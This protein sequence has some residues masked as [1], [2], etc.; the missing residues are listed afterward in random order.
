MEASRMTKEEFEAAALRRLQHLYPRA[1][2]L[3][4]GQLE[5]AILRTPS[6]RPTAHRLRLARAWAA[7]CQNGE[8]FDLDNYLT[9]VVGTV[10]HRLPPDWD[11]ARNL[12]YPKLLNGKQAITPGPAT[13]LFYS[14]TPELGYVLG[15]DDYDVFLNEEHLNLWGVPEECVLAAAMDNLGRIW[16]GATIVAWTV[17]EAIRAFHVEVAHSHKAAFV[18]V[19]DFF[20]RASDVLN[21]SEILVA[22]PNQ[23]FL[24]AFAGD[25]EDFR[26][27]LHPMLEKELASSQPLSRA[28]IRITPEGYFGEE[29][30]ENP[31]PE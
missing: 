7:F 1:R 13:P 18:L 31:D 10:E 9:R 16:Q 2:F 22:V 30:P 14:V 26:Q 3:K 23:Q 19:P 5:I 29:L 25:D 27:I 17:Q 4:A 28:L 24:V 15:C 6:G 20:D 8:R 21:A 12:I 11:S